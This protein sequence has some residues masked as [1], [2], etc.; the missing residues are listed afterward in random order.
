Y[1]WSRAAEDPR[2]PPEVLV[3]LLAHPWY[4]VAE[5]AGLNPKRS[6]LVRTSD[7]PR[8]SGSCPRESWEVHRVVLRI[9]VET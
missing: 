8:R 4:L 9:E 5:E 6:H 1:T 3:K 7:C 2:I